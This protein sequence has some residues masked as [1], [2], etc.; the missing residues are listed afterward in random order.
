MEKYF[1][2]QQDDEEVIMII[3][4]HWLHFLPHIILASV[5][6]LIGFFTVLA[7]PVIAPSL[8]NGFGYN[9]YVLV[10]SLLFLFTTANFYSAWLMHYLNV[11]LITTEHIVEICQ[12]NL[13]SRKISELGLDRIQDVSS[14]QK[15][16]METFFNYGDID[17]Q[18]AGELPNFFFHKIPDPTETSQKI[19]EIEEDY[20]KRH[21]I[22]EASGINSSSIQKTPQETSQ[23]SDSSV[24]DEADRTPQIEYP[25][26]Q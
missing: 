16:V 18:T 24:S 21:G 12:E 1:S 20:S 15:G 13:F 14:N 7:L 2:S 22:R 8:I 11:G 6:Y 4:K 9:I 5:L 23:S 3:H 25:K 19:M 17:I 10:V 26:D